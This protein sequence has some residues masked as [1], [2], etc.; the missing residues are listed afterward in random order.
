MGRVGLVSD[1]HGLIRPEVLA[2]L[3][4]VERILHA[5]DVGKPEVLE[6]LRRLAP[7]E[8][9]RGNV[10]LGRWAAGL[11]ARRVVEL[12]AVRVLLLHDLAQLDLD[13]AIEGL[14]A[15]ISGHSHRPSIRDGKGVLWLNPGSAGP[16]RFRLPVTL[17]RLDFD[18]GR[19]SPELVE[20]MPS[21]TPGSRGET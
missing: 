13:P 21:P 3:A 14:A 5:G 18:G 6:A 19:L 1:T 4:G 10:D 15:V 17:M 16:R 7:V 8:A 12:G 2:A 9:V 20:L 11:P